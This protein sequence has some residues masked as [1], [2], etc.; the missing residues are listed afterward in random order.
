LSRD[1]LIISVFCVIQTSAVVPQHCCNS[2]TFNSATTLLD[3]AV[4]TQPPNTSQFRYNKGKEVRTQDGRSTRRDSKPGNLRSPRIL[5]DDSTTNF[6]LVVLQLQM[7][8]WLDT[9]SK[10]TVVAYFK[11]ICAKGSLN[12]NGESCLS[13]LYLPHPVPFFFS[14]SLYHYLLPFSLSTVKKV[15]SLSYR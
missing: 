8:M 14:V 9:I 13:Y 4:L 1:R 7:G 6:H 2:D 3:P 15:T 11:Q 5:N 10:N 12:I